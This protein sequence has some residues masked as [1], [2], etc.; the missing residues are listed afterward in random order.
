MGA[1]D[2][3]RDAS[4]VLFDRSRKSLEA[5]TLTGLAEIERCLDELLPDLIVAA[6]QSGEGGKVKKAAVLEA[7]GRW[8]DEVIAPKDIP[9]LPDWILDPILRSQLLAGASRTIDAVVAAL[10][11]F[12]ILVEVD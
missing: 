5:I 11:R 1:I 9:Y 6:Q 12:W 4:A 7:V 8:Y 10:K 2:D 3:V